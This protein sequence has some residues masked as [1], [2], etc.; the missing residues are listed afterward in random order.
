MLKSIQTPFLAPQPPTYISL[1][2]PHTWGSLKGLG[3]VTHE[4]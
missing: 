2:S 3:V 1:V 4:V